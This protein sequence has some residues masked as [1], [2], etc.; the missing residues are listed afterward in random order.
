MDD[1]IA[2]DPFD[3]D[4]DQDGEHFLVRGHGGYLHVFERTDVL[5]IL[6]MWDEGWSTADLA[7]MY[8]QSP[9][10]VRRMLQLHRGSLRGRKP[11]ESILRRLAARMRFEGWK[12]PKVARVLGVSRTWAW[13]AGSECVELE[14]HELEIFRELFGRDLER[15][16]AESQA[17]Q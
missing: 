16:L 4:L 5:D 3:I 6:H 2:T 7:E 10:G 17:E 13:E 12:I 8:S 9:S 15:V 14:Q 1:P 11:A